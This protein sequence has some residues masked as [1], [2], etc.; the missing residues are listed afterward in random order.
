VKRSGLDNLLADLARS[1]PNLPD[2]ACKRRWRVFDEQDDPTIHPD[3]RRRLEATAIGICRTCP[4]LNPCRQWLDSL[5]SD[6]RPYGVTAGR[7]RR[8]RP[9]RNTREENTA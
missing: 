5:P 9:R 7:I 8:S 3:I 4:A 6:Q 1:I 2:A